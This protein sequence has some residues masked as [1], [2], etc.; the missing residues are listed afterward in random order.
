M[1]ANLFFLI[2]VRLSKESMKRAIQL[3][4]DLKNNIDFNYL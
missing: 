1:F 3:I 2:C 4:F